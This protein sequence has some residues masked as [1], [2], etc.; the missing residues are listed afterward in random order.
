[1]RED[2]GEGAS[3]GERGQTLSRRR[4][5]LVEVRGLM[6][7]KIRGLAF[8]RVR[9]GGGCRANDGWKTCSESPG[10]KA[11]MGG[12]KT[13]RGRGV[14]KETAREQRGKGEKED[15]TSRW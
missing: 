8:S 15:E 10:G 5:F 7:A 4:G 11:G 13:R 6:V 14:M 1:M 3:D 9:S 2:A 12:I